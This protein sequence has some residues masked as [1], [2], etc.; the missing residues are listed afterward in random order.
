[1]VGDAL[2][3]VD[4]FAAGDAI[5][6][7]GVEHTNN[8]LD[9]DW[10]EAELKVP[11]GFTEFVFLDVPGAVE[12]KFPE[13]LAVVRGPV[14]ALGD[15]VNFIPDAVEKRFGPGIL[16]ESEEEELFDGDLRVASPVP[17]GDHD[18]N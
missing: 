10:G 6:A 17:E 4:E 18:F 5:V 12:V 2:H 16:L 8:L 9:L 1:M 3:E 13:G 11:H 15:A 7:V 14:E